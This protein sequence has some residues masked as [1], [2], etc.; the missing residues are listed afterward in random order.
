MID[1]NL[2]KCYDKGAKQQNDYLKEVIIIM[3]SSAELKRIA[4]FALAD[5]W[6][7]AI[8]AGF[9]ASLLGAEV[10]INTIDINIDIP[11]PN[12]LGNSFPSV[13]PTSF[14]PV[15]FIILA[16]GLLY[17]LGCFIIGGAIKLGYSK[18]N[19]DIIDG[20]NITVRDVFSQFNR[21][22]TGLCMKLLTGIYIALWSM[23]FV[24]PGIVKTYSYA[25]TPYILCENPNMTA[26]EAITESKRIMEGHKGELFLL[27][28]SFI[29]WHLLVFLPIFATPFLTGLG[30]IFIILWLLFSFVWAMCIGFY[31]ETYRHA[32]FAAFYREI[33]KPQ[34]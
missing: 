10:S 17:F 28:L 29:G 2:K 33:T 11:I 7:P 19:L 8:L 9:I 5:K 30:I 25:M 3:K 4:Q 23:L 6:K 18:F 16:I 31:V 32:T 27:K 34:I 21:I 1:K 22:K 15:F 20:K 13:I 24:I 14:F 26:N 12:N